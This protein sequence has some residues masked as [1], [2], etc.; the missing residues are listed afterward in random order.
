MVAG[1]VFFAVYRI[2]HSVPVGET[3]RSRRGGVGD[4]TQELDPVPEGV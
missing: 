4:S 2:L 3:P 1:V